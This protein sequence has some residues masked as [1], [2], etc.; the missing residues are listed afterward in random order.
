MHAGGR[1]DTPFSDEAWRLKSLSSMLLG[2]KDVV[3]SADDHE[4]VV[5]SLISSNGGIG[6]NVLMYSATSENERDV[7]IDFH[8]YLNY[9][10]FERFICH[11]ISL[12]VSDAVVEETLLD[13]IRRKIKSNTAYLYN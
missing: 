7:A 12:A 8:Q 13:L 1:D 4:S 9:S 5:R 11:G 2:M 6:T 3:R 10:D